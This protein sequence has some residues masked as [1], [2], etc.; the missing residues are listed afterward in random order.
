M[1]T[2]IKNYWRRHMVAIALFG[3]LALVLGSVLMS[4]SV[5]AQKGGKNGTTLAAVKTLEICDSGDGTWHYSG[6]IA[7]WNEGAVA[8]QGLAIYDCIQNK[9]GAGQFQNAYC[10]N[11]DTGGQQ[12]PA[13]TTFGT[14]VIFHYSF[15]AAPLAGDIR[16]V[17]N[18]TITNHSGQPAG[19][20]FGPSPKSTWTGGTPQACGSAGG[21]TLTIG[22]WCNKPGVEWP[23][24]FNR[25]D[26]F[27]SSG[28]TWGQVVCG[29]GDNNN[30]YFQL[31]KQYVAALLNQASGASVP[32]DVQTI[33][34]SATTFFNSSSPATCDAN[35]SCGIQKD[36]AAI[37][38]L[39]NQGDS[40]LGGPPHCP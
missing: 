28:L 38:D 18:V 26:A 2:A 34:N 3:C 24:G 17:A 7:V 37:L 9:T 27:F 12:I 29:D 6:V 13:G 19:T 23:S 1:S 8:T 14:A 11:V 35:G 10:Q 36:W 15:D 5:S 33:L 30:G 39:Y 32:P 25:D 40:S 4:N 21:C 31:A 16:N 22:Y 20:P